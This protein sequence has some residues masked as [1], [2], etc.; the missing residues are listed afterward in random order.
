[1]LS[2]CLSNEQMKEKCPA[3]CLLSKRG[4]ERHKGKWRQQPVVGHAGSLQSRRRVRSA[5]LLTPRGREL[6]VVA[7]DLLSVRWG[8]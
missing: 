5:W 6:A 3:T 4:T 7:A 8:W 1:V 2:K